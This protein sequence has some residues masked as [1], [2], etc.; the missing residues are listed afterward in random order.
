MG[1]PFFLQ[2]LMSLRA[3]RRVY[4]GAG[5]TVACES[6]KASGFCEDT[7]FPERV[8][9]N[10]K[11]VAGKTSVVAWFLNTGGASFATQGLSDE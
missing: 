6:N 5:R 4:I 1:T 7:S 2:H 9:R 10:Q 11:T 3:K 8:A